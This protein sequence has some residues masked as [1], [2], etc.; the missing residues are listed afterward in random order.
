[1]PVSTFPLAIAVLTGLTVAVP[2]PVILVPAEQQLPPRDAVVRQEGGATVR[3]RVV[4]AA[5]GQPLHR[6]RVTLN[7]LAQNPPT[8]V[9]D[10][11]GEFELTNVPAGTYT[12]T[13]ARAGYLT[14]QYGQRTPREAGRPIHVVPGE[15]IE[16]IEVALYKGGVI[17]GRIADE[18]GTP[19]PGVKVEAVEPRYI[20]GRRVAVAAA[21]TTTNDLGEFRLASL[22]PG[23]YQLR[24]STT[25]AWAADDFTATF[26]HADTYYPGVT[27]SDAPVE[28][29]VSAGLEVADLA[30]RLI[31]GRAARIDG[32]VEDPGG[33][34]IASQEVHLSRIFR[35]VGGMLL[36]SGDGVTVRTDANGRFTIHPLAPGEFSLSTGGPS[37]TATT[38]VFLA[39]GDVRKVVLSPKRRTLLNGEIVIDGGV[40]PPFAAARLRV[41]PVDAGADGPLLPWGAASEATVAAD[42]K[43]RIPNMDGRYLFRVRHLPDDWMVKAVVVNGQDVTDTPLPIHPAPVDLDGVRIVISPG[44]GRISGAVRG[45]ADLPAPDVSVIVFSESRAHWGPGS[46]FVKAVR[47]DATGRFTAG[48][49][50]AGIYHVIARDVVD[51]QWDDAEYLQGLIREAQRVEVRDGQATDVTLLREER[52]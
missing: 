21:I 14:I 28:I 3:G 7:G 43:F 9:T 44:G 26:V 47:P 31:A 25:D 24:A 8:A 13:A 33:L 51:G 11:R 29:T 34:P 50:P 10:M 22:S 19:A 48:G 12:L 37:A 4:A 18:Q 27:T 16:R 2:V 30:M 6:V 32:L 42:W 49:L 52:R 23:S 35:T 40:R 15:P 17:A 38:R 5:G 45:P 20:S 39:D 1:M 41:L 36:A 46:R